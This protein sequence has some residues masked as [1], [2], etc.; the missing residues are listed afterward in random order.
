MSTRENIRLIARA[1]LLGGYIFGSQCHILVL[2]HYDLDP[3]TQF[4]NKTENISP[5]IFEVGI[6]NLVCGYTLGSRSA[7]FC[8]RVTVTKTL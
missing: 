6:Q 1:P 8:F 4:F 3:W 5:T 2:G 7:I